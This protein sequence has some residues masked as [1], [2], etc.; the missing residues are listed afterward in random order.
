MSGKSAAVRFTLPLEH[1]PPGEYLLRL[2]ATLGDR[3]TNRLVRF[4]VR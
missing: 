3:R 1:L 2:E 4:S